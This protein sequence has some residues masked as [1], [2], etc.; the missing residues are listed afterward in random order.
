MITKTPSQFA[1][2]LLPVVLVALLACCSSAFAEE[3]SERRSPPDDPMTCAQ[4]STRLGK[5]GGQSDT[6]RAQF[7]DLT[8]HVESVPSGADWEN[9]RLRTLELFPL[10]DGMAELG[11][12]LAAIRQSLDSIQGLRDVASGAPQETDTE[13][14]AQRKIADVQAVVVAN[15]KKAVENYYCR[16]VFP[17]DA[18]VFRLYDHEVPR[19][20]ECADGARASLK[21]QIERDWPGE[22]RPA[23]WQEPIYTER[24]DRCREY[25]GLRLAPVEI[26]SLPQQGISTAAKSWAALAVGAGGGWGQAWGFQ[27]REEAEARALEECG[28]NVAGCQVA[29]TFTVCAAMA[30][31]PKDNSWAWATRDDAAAAAQ[32]AMASC[33]E[34]SHSGGCEIVTQFCGDG[35]R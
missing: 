2:A 24:R 33:N 6:L 19:A 8:R 28:K 25:L 4:I 34:R 22:P 18:E 20:L 29:A 10:F 1:G 14:S 7:D 32:A 26:G 5:I 17:W 9:W 3:K 27:T 23:I 30:R 11:D 35:P 16:K 13:V 31:S 12:V 15:L 21:Q